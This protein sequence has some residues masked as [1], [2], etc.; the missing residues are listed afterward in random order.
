MIEGWA[1]IDRFGKPQLTV[2]AI[3]PGVRVVDHWTYP[4]PPG[5]RQMVSRPLS[6]ICAW[7]WQQHVEHA[8]RFFHARNA[9]EIWVRYEELIRD[10]WSVVWALAQNLGLEVNNDTA[11]SVAE[12]RL[13]RTVVSKPN[14]DKWKQSRYEQIM[15]VLP[16]IRVTASRVGYELG[17]E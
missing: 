11:A 2:D 12:R 14:S 6:E 9:G 17:K 13:S 4:A 7:T 16:M 8:L 3:Q 1:H 15:S 5:W 10:P